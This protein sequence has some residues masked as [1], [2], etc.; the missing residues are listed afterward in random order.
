MSDII[1]YDLA[2]PVKT[3]ELAAELQRFVKEQKLKIGRAHV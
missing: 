2:N 1:K 3:L